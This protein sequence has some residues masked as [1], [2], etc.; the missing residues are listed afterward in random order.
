MTHMDDRES[1]FSSWSS[2]GWV[3]LAGAASWG[4]LFVLVSA[5]VRFL[6]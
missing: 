5:L 2:L 6:R 4:V 3:V 1:L